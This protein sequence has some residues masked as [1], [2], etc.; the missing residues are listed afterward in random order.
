[1]TK[2]VTI[3]VEFEGT[4]MS[5]VLLFVCPIRNE[6]STL[7]RLVESL[8]RQSYTHWVLHIVDN[9]SD[10]GSQG[11]ARELA[12]QDSRVRVTECVNLVSANQNWLR[13][14]KFALTM[15]SEAV[16]WIAGDD[17]LGS[18]MYIQDA[19]E[20][21][22][23]DI[24]CVLPHVL[25]RRVDHELTYSLPVR[26][27]SSRLNQLALARNSLYAMAI[28]AVYRRAE[29]ERLLDSPSATLMGEFYA[30]SDWWWAFEALRSP[31][32]YQVDSSLVKV[33]RAAPR[34][35][36]YYSGGTVSTST[37]HRMRFQGRASQFVTHT[38]V[39]PV[40]RLV[41]QRRRIS[42]NDLPWLVFMCLTEMA[43]GLV[44]L[45]TRALAALKRRNS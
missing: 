12:R 32:A 22:K 38:F 40:S 29:F 8:Q 33:A 26:A 44:V 36:D 4:C 6:A 42:R 23:G 13:A 18:D 5:P 10:D 30:A 16:A 9:A 20:K 19:M 25:E 41:T 3:R 17:Y 1:M 27:G 15:K 21:L 37:L 11:V 39:R 28:Y 2:V 14:A 24:Q 31:C 34:D 43:Q 45:L 35:R 7:K